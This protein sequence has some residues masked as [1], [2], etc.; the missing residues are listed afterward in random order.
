MFPQ[1]SHPVAPSLNSVRHYGLSALEHDRRFEGL[2]LSPYAFAIYL[3]FVSLLRSPSRIPFSYV[4]PLHMPS[5][6]L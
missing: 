6:S 2:C 4:H 1:F 5:C 3:A